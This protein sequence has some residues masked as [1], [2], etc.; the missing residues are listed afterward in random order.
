MF[1]RLYKNVC[2]RREYSG[3]SSNVW[4]ACFFLKQEVKITRRSGSNRDIVHLYVFSSL[5]TW[6]ARAAL[7]P[8][9]HGGRRCS[10]SESEPRHSVRYHLKKKIRAALLLLIQTIPVIYWTNS[11]HFRRDNE[12]TDLFFFP[13]H[14]SALMELMKNVISLTISNPAL[15]YLGFTRGFL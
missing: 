2:E 6:W 9:T 3:G 8:E 12:A 13:R 10:L 14:T 15:R 11:S 5:E 4:G 7:Q 1:C